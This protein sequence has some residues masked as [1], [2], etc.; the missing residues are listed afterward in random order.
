[1]PLFAQFVEKRVGNFIVASFVSPVS[2][3][4]PNNIRNFRTS[5]CNEGCVAAYAVSDLVLDEFDPRNFGY[6]V[7]EPFSL[8]LS[9][10]TTL[11]TYFVEDY[12]MYA[13]H[14]TSP[15]TVFPS[16]GEPG[17]EATATM[18]SSAEISAIREAHR[19]WDAFSANPDFLYEAEDA[20]E[21]VWE[22]DLVTD[23]IAV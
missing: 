4:R 10:D 23:D 3:N 2:H 11:S 17:V 1:M 22:E 8:H 7:V 19:E 20:A 6:R 13:L 18:L 12:D 5:P 21:C 9:S 15:V 14:N 16:T